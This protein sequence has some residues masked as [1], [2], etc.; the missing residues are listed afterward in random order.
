VDASEEKE[1]A[2]MDI[3]A[4]AL[5]DSGKTT[6]AIAWQKKAI[7]A[8]SEDADQKKELEGKL[9]EYQEKVAAK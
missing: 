7:A 4:R 2:T 6:D 3:Y 5:F 1:P 9:K 8:A